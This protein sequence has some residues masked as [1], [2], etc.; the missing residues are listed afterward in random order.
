MSCSIPAAWHSSATH[1]IRNA[2]MVSMSA[3]HAVGHGFEPRSGHTKDHHNNCTNCLPAWHAGIS[4]GE[5][6]SAA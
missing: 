2:L 4:L 3:S 5:F 1:C 6:D